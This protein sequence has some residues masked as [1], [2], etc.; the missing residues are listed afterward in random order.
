MSEHKAGK[1]SGLATDLA[2]N[3][4]QHGIKRGWLGAVLFTCIGLVDWNGQ[5]HFS[6]SCEL[7]VGTNDFNT[8]KNFLLRSNPR[9]I[10][11]SGD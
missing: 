3:T 10:F 1:A 2:F 9:I 11:L 8:K 4:E 7:W 5:E 6:L